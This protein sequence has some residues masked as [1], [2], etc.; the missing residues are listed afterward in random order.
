MA[1]KGSGFAWINGDGLSLFDVDDEVGEIVFQARNCLNHKLSV[2]LFLFPFLWSET[3]IDEMTVA[4][5]KVEAELLGRDQVAV[6]FV[7]GFAV[8]NSGAPQA[9]IVDVKLDSASTSGCSLFEDRLLEFCRQIRALSDADRVQ[10]LNPDKSVGTHPPSVALESF[11]R[12][13]DGK[14]HVSILLRELVLK[15]QNRFQLPYQEAELCHCRAVPTAVVDRAIVGGCHSTLSVA[16]TTS[17]GTSCGTCKLDTELL[18]AYRLGA[19]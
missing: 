1:K 18:I 7:L 10:L 17:A 16:R 13:L 3:L 6:E 5:K 14:D 12:G 15:L 19:L 4:N 8:Q 2:H 9:M 11:Y